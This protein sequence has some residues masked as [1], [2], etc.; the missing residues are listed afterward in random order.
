MASVIFPAAETAR[1]ALN[2]TGARSTAL[3]ESFVMDNS[4]DHAP[5]R[6]I[7]CERAGIQ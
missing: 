2:A 7:A 3:L 5:L 6:Q 1:T 4:F